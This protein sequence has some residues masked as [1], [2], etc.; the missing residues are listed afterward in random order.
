VTPTPQ[1]GC[2]T[3]TA[4]TTNA[5]NE[6]G[7]SSYHF[8]TN[9]E[10]DEVSYTYSS[11]YGLSSEDYDEI[12][13]IN[14]DYVFSN[15]VVGSNYSTSSNITD[16]DDNYV[17]GCEG[18]WNSEGIDLTDETCTDKNWFLDNC[19]VF[20]PLTN[21]QYQA[22]SINFKTLRGQALMYSDWLCSSGDQNWQFDYDTCQWVDV[23]SQQC[24]PSLLIKLQPKKES[25]HVS[26][27]F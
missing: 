14:Y 27:K 9:T 13:N 19:F 23:A 15:G 5:I 17:N 2:Q 11:N 16:G 12:D 1:P 7:S 8:H 24:T 4:L 25:K 10:S 21:L 18:W 6:H 22:S 26:L 20:D 3:Q